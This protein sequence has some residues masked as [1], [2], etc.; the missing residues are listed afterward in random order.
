MRRATTT[1]SGAYPKTY[2]RAG[3]MLVGGPLERRSS[4]RWHVAIL[5]CIRRMGIDKGL[6]PDVVEAELGGVGD[7]PGTHLSTLRLA[8]TRVLGEPV[9][10]LSS[11]H[12]DTLALGLEPD[13]LRRIAVWMARRVK[14]DDEARFDWYP[15]GWRRELRWIFGHDDDTHEQGREP[16][17]DDE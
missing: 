16:G 12:G 1:T 5:A 8:T 4:I 10:L 13:E 11:F 9:P 6:T 3:A 15:D 7:L 17:S 14:A 2:S